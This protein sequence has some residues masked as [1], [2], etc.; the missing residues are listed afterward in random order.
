M[1]KTDE[2]P[3]GDGTPRRAAFR[4]GRVGY[5]LIL[6]CLFLGFSWES[7]R[8]QGGVINYECGDLE[9]GYGP[10]DYR[11]ATRESKGLVE[12]AHFSRDVE[13]LKGYKAIRL[14]GLR[15]D[16]GGDIDY[17]LRAFPNHPRALWA[18]V[19]LS[20]KEKKEQPKG[21]NWIVECY[22]DRAVRFR[23]DD[24]NVRV[25]YA[26]FLIKRKRTAEAAA[27]LDL[28]DKAGDAESANFYYNLGLALADVQR[29]ERARVRAN[30]AYELGFPLPGLKDKLIKAGQWN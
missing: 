30:Q 18:M 24:L 1:T 21:A 23:P 28:A 19:R 8:A 11:V 15:G 20:E 7:A 9:N 16:P 17:T 13:N 22:F 12:G 10:F 4:C 2:W 6:G 5:A 29:W 14:G 26:N 3:D 27:Q 25:I